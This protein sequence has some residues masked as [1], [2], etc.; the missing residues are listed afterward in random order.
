[1]YRT[2]VLR[3]ARVSLYPREDVRGRA[4][5]PADRADRARARPIMDRAPATTARTSSPPRPPERDDADGL[6]W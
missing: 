5:P 4:P 2:E 3:N 6:C 1:M